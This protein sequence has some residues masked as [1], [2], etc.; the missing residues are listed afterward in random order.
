MQLSKTIKTARVKKGLTQLELANKL[1]LDNGMF[2][3]LIESG[4]SKAP[5]KTIGKMINILD[6]PEKKIITHLVNEF[7]KEL[8]NEINEGKC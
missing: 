5:F 8:V 1:G 4:K 7:K 3:S 6:L 2:V